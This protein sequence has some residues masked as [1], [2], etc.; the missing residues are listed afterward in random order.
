MLI[1]NW[2]KVKTCW[3]LHPTVTL[4]RNSKY[5]LS[6][7]NIFLWCTDKFFTPISVTLH[8][9][10]KYPLS[11]VSFFFR[12]TSGRASEELRGPGAEARE[13]R[14]GHEPPDQAGLALLLQLPVQGQG[15]QPSEDHSEG[16]V[17]VGADDR[18]V[19]NIVCFMICVRIFNQLTWTKKSDV[20]LKYCSIYFDLY[21]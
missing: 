5:P 18:W 12:Q 4:Q 7:V 9:Y 10:S 6:L 2:K 20:K 15:A 16:A 14:G 13:D 3:F 17:E 8:P 11:L 19:R 21:F 1:K